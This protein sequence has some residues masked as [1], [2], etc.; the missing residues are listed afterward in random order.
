M[1]ETF[2]AS[3]QRVRRRVLLFNLGVLSA[4]LAGLADIYHLSTASRPNDI[5]VY[6]FACLFAIVFG[7]YPV[8]SYVLTRCIRRWNVGTCPQCHQPIWDN[9]IVATETAISQRC[10]RCGESLQWRQGFR[11]M[12]APEDAA[13]RGRSEMRSAS[14]DRR[15]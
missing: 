5:A 10:P 15:P 4:G 14:T 1:D 9:T 13:R 7:T 6:G 11:V 12:P 3:F 2:A 8:M